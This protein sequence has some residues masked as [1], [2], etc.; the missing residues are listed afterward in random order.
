MQGPRLQRM[1]L[2]ALLTSFLWEWSILD[3]TPLC[4][5]GTNIHHVPHDSC[6][7][8]LAPSLPGPQFPY[9]EKGV[10]ILSL[11]LE[12]ENLQARNAGQ[13]CGYY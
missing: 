11:I 5:R 10:I 7:T 4:V 12:V 6:S 2:Q 8:I 1:D 13:R 3:T 9:L